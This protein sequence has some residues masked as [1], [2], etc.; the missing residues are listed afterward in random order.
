MYK[1]GSRNNLICDG[2]I[3]EAFENCFCSIVKKTYRNWITYFESP[4][5]IL[6]DDGGEF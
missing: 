1:I 6:S 2:D 5:Q 3:A 4:K